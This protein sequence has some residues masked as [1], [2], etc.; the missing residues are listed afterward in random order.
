[1][2]VKVAEVLAPALRCCRGMPPRPDISD[3]YANSVRRDAWRAQLLH[4]QLAEQ[5]A[6]RRAT[7][8]MRRAVWLGVALG[9]FG[10]F[11]LYL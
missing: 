3:L 11:A 6:K 10:S 4:E 9:V 5:S 7:E 8:A 2:A 1:M